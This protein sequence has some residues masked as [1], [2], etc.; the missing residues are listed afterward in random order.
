MGESARFP[1]SKG[2]IEKGNKNARHIGTVWGE[3]KRY[4]PNGSPWKLSSRADSKDMHKNTWASQND[5]G[6]ICCNFFIPLFSYYYCQVT[7][8]IT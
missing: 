6:P 7:T 3:A 5:M 1:N 8:V 4:V 2:V